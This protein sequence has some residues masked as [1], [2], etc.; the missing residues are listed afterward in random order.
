MQPIVVDGKWYIEVSTP[1]FGKVL[2]L[3]K[4]DLPIPISFD[5]KEEAQAY[6]DNE[7][8]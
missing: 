5:T 4:T 6:I 3:E 2:L 8:K 1:E 7:R